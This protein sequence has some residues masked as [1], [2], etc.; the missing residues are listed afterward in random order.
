MTRPATE[1]EYAQKYAEY[2]AA[3]RASSRPDVREYHRTGKQWPQDVLLGRPC[4]K[5]AI[6][7]RALILEGMRGNLGWL[8]AFEVYQ[9]CPKIT[10]KR[11]F[12]T[13]ILW[14]TGSG[15]VELDRSGRYKLYRLGGNKG[16]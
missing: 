15:E 2:A 11:R 10:S 5:E 16:E 8:R 1:Q 9:L 12:E 13:A 4:T 3:C 14:L 6:K 7:T